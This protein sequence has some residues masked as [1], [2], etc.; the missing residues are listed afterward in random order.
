MLNWAITLLLLALVSIVFAIGGTDGEVASLLGRI[1]AAGCLVTA[2][3]MFVTHV[4]HRHRR[5]GAR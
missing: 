5:P 3:G 1:A 4:K 2:L